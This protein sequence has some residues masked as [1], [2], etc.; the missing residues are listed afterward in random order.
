MR[1]ATFALVFAFL[2][3]VSLQASAQSMRRSYQKEPGPKFPGQKAPVEPEQEAAPYQ[4]GAGFVAP[5][6]R[7][8]VAGESSALGLE[9]M[10]I[11]FPALELKFPNLRF[12]C[13][14]HYRTP[15]RMLLEKGVAPLVQGAREEVSLPAP[16]QEGAPAPRQE[17]APKMP[18]QSKA[19]GLQGDLE[20]RQEAARLAAIERAY[21]ERMLQLEQSEQRLERRLESLTTAVEKL[22]E[23]QALQAA[24]MARH[25]AP[26]ETD[27]PNA[28]FAPTDAAAPA[29]ASPDRGSDQAATS[30]RKVHLIT[31]KPALGETP[32]EPRIVPVDDFEELLRLPGVR[33]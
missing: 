10:S 1:V 26:V 31:A 8:P 16:A 23:L 6:A 24:R 2:L 18:V 30:L 7:G 25:P 20:A 5:P 11:E 29:S 21:H 3:A 12:P 4:E 28:C 17:G 32:R 13:F 14:T 15:P 19:F 9:G 22:V 33:R 27:T